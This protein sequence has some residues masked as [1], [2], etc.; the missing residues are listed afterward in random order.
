MDLLLGNSG[1][2]LGVR[3]GEVQDRHLR[4]DWPPAPLHVLPLL[5]VPGT[6]SDDGGLHV[7]PRVVQPRHIRRLSVS[8]LG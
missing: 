6:R 1:A 4:H 3:G 8:S 7:L 2:V 5:E